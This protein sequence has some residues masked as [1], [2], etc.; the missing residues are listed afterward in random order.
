MLSSFVPGTTMQADK[1]EYNIM[2]K[3][4]TAE[5]MSW[6]EDLFEGKEKSVE[7]ADN[8]PRRGNTFERNPNQTKNGTGMSPKLMNFT[9]NLKAR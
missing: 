6:R 9:F 3:D 1:K 7:Q 2:K 5:K 4:F 8:P